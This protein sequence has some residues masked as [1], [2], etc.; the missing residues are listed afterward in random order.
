MRLGVAC[1]AKPSIPPEV[2]PF[3]MASRKLP[4]GDRARQVDGY[5]E[6]IWSSS[7]ALILSC[8]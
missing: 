4:G 5:D 6:V 3:A 1:A 2:K 7:K 8:L